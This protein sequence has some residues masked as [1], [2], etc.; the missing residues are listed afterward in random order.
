M[1][2]AVLPSAEAVLAGER[3]AIA[4]ALTLIE[5]GDPAAA[6]LLARLY[7]HTGQAH[8][9][10]VTGAPGTGKSTLVTALAQAYRAA[11]QTVAVIAVDPSSP[12]TGGA[13][14]GDRIR[15][16]DLSGDRGV[17][18]RSMA[19]RGALGG[20]AAA[21]A[22]AVRLLDAA[23][24]SVIL[25]ETVGAGQNEVAIAR[26]AQTTLVVEAPGLGD[27]VQASKAGI[28]EIADIL[29]VNKADRPGANA[30]AA[31]LRT[32]LEIG[33]PAAKIGGMLAV[34]PFGHH[35]GCVAT[36]QPHHSPDPAVPFWLP[37]IILTSAIQPDALLP[38]SAANAAAGVGIPALLTA[39]A[40]HR[41]YLAGG[42]GAAL[43]ADQIALE[44]RDRL[45]V[46]LLTRLLATLPP[47]AFAAAVADVQSRQTAPA[48]AVAALLNAAVSAP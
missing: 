4:R 14:L 21:A 41:A 9:I 45:H 10:G 22:D 32:M 17:F 38:Q 11:G 42:D 36:G 19:T 39:I 43:E 28:L 2:T 30:T 7:P 33:H 37:P 24:F 40:D 16:R 35:R 26:V 46:A 12:Y 13:L 29:V 3:R 34:D 23:G 20:L 6:A 48:T 25:I 1:P 5:R 15:M 8:R 47:G 27:D 31:A 18:I 44:L